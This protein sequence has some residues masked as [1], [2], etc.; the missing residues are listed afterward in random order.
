LAGGFAGVAVW[1][2]DAVVA[3][4]VCAA[5]GIRNDSAASTEAANRS[6]DSK[7]IRSRRTADTPH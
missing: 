1:A 7:E 4:G 5:A 2:G 6:M 3:G